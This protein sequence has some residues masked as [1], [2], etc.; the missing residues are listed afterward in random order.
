MPKDPY[1]AI[2]ESLEHARPQLTAFISGAYNAQQ[3]RALLK[4][5]DAIQ[6]AAYSYVKSKKNKKKKDGDGDSGEAEQV[7]IDWLDTEG[8]HLWN[9]A[10]QVNRA[11]ATTPELSKDELSTVAALRLTGF[12]LV[13]AATDIK[14]PTTF[15]IRLL[16]LTAKTMTALLEAG[17]APMA[18]QLALQGAEYEQLITSSTTIKE[19]SELKQKVT[20]LVW[21][22]MARIDFLLREGND[23]FAYDLLYK[24]TQLDETWSMTAQE[25]RLL[26]SKCW[27]VG[28]HMLNERT[29]VSGSIDWLKQGILLIEKLINRGVQLDHLKELHLND[30]A[31]AQLMKAE[32]N[33]HALNSAAAAL[34]ELGELVADS[35]QATLHEMRL[36]QLHI[37][38]TRKA[39]DGE[40]RI[41]MED[42]MKLTDWTEE[43]VLEILSQLASLIGQY[44]ALPSQL[45]QTY[46]RLALASSAGHPYV[47]MIM[48][49]G[50]LFMKALSPPTAGV[51]IAAGILDMISKDPDYQL[52]D[53][54][55]AIACQTL[56]WNIGMFNESKEKITEAAHWYQLAAHTV[57]KELGG[58]NISRCFR[59]AALCHMKMTD[60][61][62]ALDLISLCPKEEA[63]THYLAFLAAIRQGREEAA[64]GAVSSIVEC[65]DFEAQQLVLMASLANEKGAKHVLIASMR[66]LL[67]TLT[68]SAVKFDVQIETITVIR[69]L[70]RMTAMEW[71]HAEDKD[72]L[73][74]SMIEY[75]Q[76]AIDILSEDPTRGQGQMKGIAWL[77]KCAYNVAVQGL[78]TLSSKS[79]ADLFDVSA[80]LMSIYDVIETSGAT[81]PDLHFV[82]GSAMFACLCGKIFFCRDLS[83]GPDKVLLLDQLLDYIPHCREALS[84]VKST[85]PRWPVISH[86]RRIIDTSEVELQCES[87]EWTAI[88]PILQRI[89]KAHSSG[90]I[91]E[92]NRTLEMMANVLFQYE[93]CPS[94]ITYQLLE[95]ILDTCPTAK[96]NDVKLYSRWMRAILRILLHR[97]GGEEEAESLKYA[98]K[99]L[100][101]LKTSLGK[102]AY[103]L[104][105]IQWLVATFWNKGLEWF[106]SSRVSQAKAWCEIAMTIAANTPELNIDRQKMNEHY[107]HLLSKINR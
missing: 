56:L 49:E 24:A 31:R 86:M 104:D 65:S 30:S 26:A 29:N 39:P 57:F 25:C 17:K 64:I 34:N 22:Y 91:I 85:H 87:N 84:S 69:C 70:L 23:S 45:V 18:S 103:P 73:V 43:S 71:A 61:T 10:S 1:T 88:P 38:K 96:A 6:D 44:P 66:A 33:P 36:L 35:D 21:Y 89:K 67:N 97:N 40:L 74:E 46:L 79:L 8:V 19:A 20:V 105:E 98:E 13:E 42:I 94:H 2:Q 9:L 27:T 28:N 90:E 41:V 53:K 15:L 48:Y 32:E 62:A 11:T 80:Q 83:S 52:D 12:R 95:L 82:R 107:Q 92:T 50:L 78:N 16:G 58:E 55:S 14:G 7:K 81:D 77:Y 100:D 102:S 75:L 54:V 59:K 76:T 99:A 106:S 72:R 60:W 4:L 68:Y 63:S 51:R 101:V 37:L 93:E 3:T 5:L 47:R